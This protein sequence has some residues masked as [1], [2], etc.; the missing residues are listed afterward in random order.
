MNVL[1]NLTQLSKAGIWAIVNESDKVLYITQSNNVLSSMSRN[2]DQLNNKSHHCR[3]LLRHKS[4]L[5][6]VVL[7]YVTIETDRK[8]RLNYWIEK[9]RNK[10]YT[11]YRKHNGEALYVPKILVT[12]DFKIHVT[13]VN[14]RND[15]LVVGVFDKMSEAEHFT[16][17][18]YSKPFYTITY[19]SNILTKEYLKGKKVIG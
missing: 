5:S 3:S 6:F 19:S 1:P 4:K 10:G 14:R 16:T 13:L 8:L 11:L 15:K 18:H 12:E 2:I 17:T 9:Y 7:E